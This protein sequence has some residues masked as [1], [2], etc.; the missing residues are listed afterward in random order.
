VS[1]KKSQDLLKEISKAGAPTKELP[2]SRIE[3]LMKAQSLNPSLPCAVFNGEGSLIG[4]NRRMKGLIQSELKLPLEWSELEM[5]WPFHNE[6]DAGPALLR[7]TISHRDD[8]NPFVVL[9]TAQL[10]TFKLQTILIGSAK[11]RKAPERL[12]VAEIVR[13]GDLLGDK[14]SR[15]VLFR[16][17]S[18]EI[19]TSVMAMNGYLGIIESQLHDVKVVQES[20]DRLKALVKRL[21]SV[22]T[23]LDDFR[24][25]LGVL[26]GVEA[27]GTSRKK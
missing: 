22:V 17:L 13:S 9:V 7:K 26:D 1:A 5:L 4:A 23:R 15:Q 12:V 27:S 6:D 11:D 8:K 3:A 16:T 19:R 21:E 18:H 20:T 14:E 10:K 25:E 2:L 24:V